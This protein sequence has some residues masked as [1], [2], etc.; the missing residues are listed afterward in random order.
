MGHI[1]VV[2][3]DRWS[4][5]TG[6]TTLKY[7]TLCQEYL[8]FQERGSIKTGC[9]VHMNLLWRVEVKTQCREINPWSQRYEIWVQLCRSDISEKPNH[10]K[11]ICY[12]ADG[13]VGYRA[14]RNVREREG[15]Q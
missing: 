6:S 10:A 14:W 8:V 9:T 1:N 4:L 13:N 12:H 7:R 2:S 11:L 3:Q 15:D 5:V